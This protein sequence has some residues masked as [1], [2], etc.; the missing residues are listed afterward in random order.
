MKVIWEIAVSRL[1]LVWKDR[2]NGRTEVA[3]IGQNRNMF[4]ENS[5]KFW[6]YWTCSNLYNRND[7]TFSFYCGIPERK[8]GT[9]RSHREQSVLGGN[10]TDRKGK[11]ILENL[12]NY[13]DSVINNDIYEPTQISILG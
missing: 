9:V 12:E 4:Y 2:L 13:P 11:Q 8:I 5:N 3:Y 7:L 1:T 6:I 10:F